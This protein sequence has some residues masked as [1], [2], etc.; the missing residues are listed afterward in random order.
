[1]LNW[2]SFQ[3]SWNTEPLNDSRLLSQV[4]FQPSS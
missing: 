4:V 3:S 2:K 1:M